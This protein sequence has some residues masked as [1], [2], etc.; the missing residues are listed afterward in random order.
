MKK[1]IYYLQLSFVLFLVGK[2]ANAQWDVTTYPGTKIFANPTTQLVGIGVNNPL[3]TLDVS[4]VANIWSGSRFAAS[5]NKM[6]PGSLTIGNLNTSFGGNSG[7]TSNNT[8]GLLMETNASTE[9]AVHHSGTRIASFLQYEGGSNRIN[10]GRDMGWG[11]IG[12]VNIL[13]NVGIGNANP[14]HKL[15]VEGNVVIGQQYSYL[16]FRP[17]VANANGEWA[18]EYEIP[19][20]G[21]NFWKPWPSTNNGNY[22]LFLKDNGNIGI[23]TATPAYKL[24][25]CGTIRSK[26]VR[27]EVGW[28]DYVF[29]PTYKLRP[30]SEV[31]SFIAKNKHLPEIPSQ[32][33]VE[34]EGL[35]MGEMQALHMKKIEELTLYII[36]LN[37]KIEQ[38]EAKVAAVTEN[39]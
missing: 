22:F 11:T 30:L 33:V 26:E 8:A 28:C 7:W 38:L 9:I 21:L 14:T 10:I 2:T 25:V 37:K 5:N 39:K 6:L 34:T 29:E 24:D 12:K 13:G 4:G 36:E 3:V 16:S 15:N 20:G 27:V 32:A 31:E 1:V 17:N 35:A 23:G 19:N 18:L